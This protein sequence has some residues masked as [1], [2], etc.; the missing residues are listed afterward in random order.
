LFGPVL[1]RLHAATMRRRAW[2]HEAPP[3][4]WQAGVRL[5][6]LVS[7]HLVAS[8]SIRLVEDDISMPHEFGQ[9]FDVCRVANLLNRAY[10]PEVTLAAMATNLLAR[11]RD[12][13]LLVVCRTTDGSEGD[14]NHATVLRRCGSALEVVARLNGGSEVEDLLLTT[15]DAPQR[16][17]RLSQL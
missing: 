11:V 16:V 12:G 7:R 10:F 2:S 14:V 8:S 17:E 4:P 15:L 13:G 9:T 6:D 3:R 1:S 5:V